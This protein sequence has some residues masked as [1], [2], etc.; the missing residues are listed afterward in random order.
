VARKVVLVVVLICFGRLGWAQSGAK[1]GSGDDAKIRAVITAQTEAWNNGDVEGFMKA[2][3]DS[4]ETTFIGK[5]VK[6]GYKPILERYKEGYSTREQ[7]G[8]L[9]FS[10]IDVRL[11]PNGCG[12]TEIALVT[13]KFHLERTARGTST[14]DDG[15]YSLVWRKG[16]DGWKIILDHTS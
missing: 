15:I 16:K 8:T 14:K 13:G 12:K 3:E 2:Y 4:T 5:T 1:S 11:L 6:K 10:D 9:T 7:M